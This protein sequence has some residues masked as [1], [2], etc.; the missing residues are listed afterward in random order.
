MIVPML[1]LLIFGTCVRDVVPTVRYLSPVQIQ[2]VYSGIRL[3]VTTETDAAT[4]EMPW[5]YASPPP[6]DDGWI[7]TIEPV[8]SRIALARS[9]VQCGD[10]I[11]LSNP[12]SN[13]FVGTRATVNGLEVLPS[14]RVRDESNHWTVICRHPPF[15][16]RDEQIHLRNVR[17]GCFLATSLAGRPNEKIPKFN[18]TCG[19]LTSNAV[20]QSGEGVYFEDAIPIN[21]IDESL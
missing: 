17:H 18:V 12:V 14:D 16:I 9:P 13:L 2:N 4:H 21:P 1:P 3:S 20:W 19:P 15:W 11:S 10:N 8:H 7:W 5:I 6:F